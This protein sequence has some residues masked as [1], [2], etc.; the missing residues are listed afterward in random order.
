MANKKLKYKKQIDNYCNIPVFYMHFLVYKMLD[1]NCRIKFHSIDNDVGTPE[2]S[3]HNKKNYPKIGVQQSIFAN[4][5]TSVSRSITFWHVI[6]I[7]RT[8]S[9][10]THTHLFSFWPFIVQ[11]FDDLNSYCKMLSIFRFTAFD[12]RTDICPIQFKKWNIKSYCKTKY[13][14]AGKLITFFFYQKQ[15]VSLFLQKNKIIKS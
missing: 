2:K 8:F 15:I 10:I 4:I 6:K 5:W 7:I 12:S 11:L 14:K 3:R 1:Y 13:T 9:S